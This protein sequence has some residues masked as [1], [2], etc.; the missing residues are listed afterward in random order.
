MH[1]RDLGRVEG[2]LPLL[3][4]PHDD[5]RDEITGT[6]RVIVEHAEH[7]CGITQKAEFLVQFA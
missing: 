3:A 4:D 7:I 6:G 5:G 2:E 1:A